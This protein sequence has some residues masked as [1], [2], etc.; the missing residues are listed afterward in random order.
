MTEFDRKHH[1]SVIILA[2]TIN[3]SQV[4]VF[5]VFRPTLRLSVQG[6][7]D[8]TSDVVRNVSVPTAS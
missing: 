5:D 3:Q 7:K 2:R 8:K 6:R 4:R 1:G